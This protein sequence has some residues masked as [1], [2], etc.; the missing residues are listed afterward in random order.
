MQVSGQLRSTR[1]T[2]MYPN[3]RYPSSTWAGAADPAAPKSTAGHKTA[4]QMNGRPSVL[5]RF[6]ELMGPAASPPAWERKTRKMQ[7]E[8]SYPLSRCLPNGVIM[9]IDKVRVPCPSS[10]H[11]QPSIRNIFWMNAPGFLF[12]SCECNLP[13]AC[14]R[15]RWSSGYWLEAD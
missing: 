2:G 1:V 14:S 5:G 3:P 7:Y 6:G 10:E 13:W 4:N 12:V 11:S 8:K 15:R 9:S